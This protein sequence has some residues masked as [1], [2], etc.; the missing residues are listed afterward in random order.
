MFDCLAAVRRRQ[1]RRQAQ[2]RRPSRKSAGSQRSRQRQP[3]PEEQPRQPAKP[4]AKEAKRSSRR[5]PRPAS[6][7]SGGRIGSRS[8]WRAIRRPGSTRPAAPSCLQQWQVLV[9]R[10]IGPPWAVTVEPDSGPLAS[11]DCQTSSARG[12]R[13]LHGVR[14]VWVVR[15]SGSEPSGLLLVGR[16]YDTASRRLGALQR[17]RLDAASDAPRALLQF[18]LDL[19]NPTA[20]ITGQEG[21]GA[22]LK[23]QGGAITPASP[24]GAVVTKGMVFIPL[25]LVSLARRQSADPE[26]SVHVPASRI[27]RGP[28][29]SVRDHQPDARP[30]LEADGAAEQPGRARDQAGKYAASS[31]GS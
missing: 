7:S 13:R 15:V 26:D 19:F 2:Q 21:G 5:R 20:E 31:S 9:K 12:F 24:F 23:V 29:G 25:R 30:A 28:G 27:G 17:S 22:L 3:R 10:F 18:A 16:E 6:R 11:V 8:I 14:K 1:N 4:A